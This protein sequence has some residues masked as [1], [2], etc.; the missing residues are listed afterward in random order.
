MS[1]TYNI[2]SETLGTYLL[3]TDTSAPSVV[4]D[5]PDGRLRLELYQVCRQLEPINQ[6]FIALS[7]ALMGSS[8][9]SSPSLE[10]HHIRKRPKYF[11]I[12]VLSIRLRG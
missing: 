3:A 10:K 9:H 1:F 8:T 2:Y 7:A 12:L 4:V 5:V 11:G 6:G